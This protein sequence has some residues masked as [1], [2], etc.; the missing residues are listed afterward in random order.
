MLRER[1]RKTG[2]C[3]RPPLF[4]RWWFWRFWV[5][6]LLD[7]LR[8]GLQD[9]ILLVD[10]TLLNIIHRQ[11]ADD[12]GGKLSNAPPLT[13]PPPPPQ[14]KEKQ[15]MLEKPKPVDN[16]N[17]NGCACLNASLIEVYSWK[18]VWIFIFPRSDDCL[19]LIP[20]FVS[21]DCNSIIW[22]CKKGKNTQ[23]W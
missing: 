6:V 2:S 18:K 21:G 1:E 12:T 8:R 5:D 15:L 13:P 20:H 9:P 14:K 11:M 3:V 7:C 19:Y 23:V 17:E 10:V 22:P 16:W 4:C